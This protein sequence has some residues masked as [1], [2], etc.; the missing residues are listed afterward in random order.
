MFVRR[1]VIALLLLDVRPMDS[2]TEALVNPT[3][4]FTR[5]SDMSPPP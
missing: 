3:E 1:G 2:A 5:N 4:S